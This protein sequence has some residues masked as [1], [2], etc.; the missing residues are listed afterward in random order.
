[1]S[2]K[3][4]EV[5]KRNQGKGFQFAHPSASRLLLI[6][7]GKRKLKGKPMM[8]ADRERLQLQTN[9]VGAENQH[10]VIGE[11]ETGNENVR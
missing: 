2:G 7:N 1:M 6:Y 4:E 8:M 11:T 5:T 10:V 9:L 3:S